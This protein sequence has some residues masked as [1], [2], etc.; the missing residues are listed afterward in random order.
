MNRRNEGRQTAWSGVGTQA[1]LTISS[2]IKLHSSPPTQLFN[3]F[4]GFSVGSCIRAK[5]FSELK[6]VS[7]NLPVHFQ[8]LVHMRGQPGN[9]A[10]FSGKH[11]FCYKGI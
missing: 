4:S 5:V 6:L 2:N 7:D 1:T 3:A 8:S 11:D 9:E 10:T